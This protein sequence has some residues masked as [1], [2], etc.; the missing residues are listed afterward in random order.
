[1]A[2]DITII[3][4][5]NKNTIDKALIEATKENTNVSLEENE[6]ELDGEIIEEE[7]VNQNINIEEISNS[8]QNEIVSL[9]GFWEKSD[10]NELNFL[11]ENTK[12]TNSHVLNNI[13][14]SF[15]E[16]DSSIPDNFTKDEFNN[17]K[18]N[19]LIK[20]GQLDKAFDLINLYQS[21]NNLDFYNLLSPEVFY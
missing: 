21:D 6:I 17:I 19:E 16:S 20:H 1:M 18:I 8:E 3:E 12:L 10:K 11:F 13:L 14:I 9:P 4:L 7:E 5:H 2:E 15:L